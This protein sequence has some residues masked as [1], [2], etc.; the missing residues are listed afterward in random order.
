MAWWVECRLVL[1]HM[2]EEN[3]SETFCRLEEVGLV[4]MLVECKPDV[5][6]W[7]WCRPEEKGLACKL[8]ECKPEE[9]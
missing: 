9:G 8:V 7:V 2:K 5:G 6:G 4:C 3:S 1:G